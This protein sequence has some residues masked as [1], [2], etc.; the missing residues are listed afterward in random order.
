MLRIRED[1]DLKELEKFG[2]EL[3]EDRYSYYGFTQ[4]NS[5]SEIRIYIDVETR[6]I[7]TGFDMYVDPYK[8]HDK[9]A[10]VIR[11]KKRLLEMR[12]NYRRK[13]SYILS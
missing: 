11:D 12:I 2:F 1:V 9:I 4:P 13:K 10:L 3:Y 6:K 8:I 7:S 5:N